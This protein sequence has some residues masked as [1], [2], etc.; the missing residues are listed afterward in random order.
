MAVHLGKV[1]RRAGDRFPKFHAGVG[2]V[3]AGTGDCKVAFIGDSTTVGAGTTGGATKSPPARFAAR[4]TGA[5]TRYGSTWGPLGSGGPWDGRLTVGAGWTTGVSFNSNGLGAGG[6][7]TNTGGGTLSFTPAAAFDT[8]KCWYLRLSAK[9]T[10]TVNVDGG[11]SL[12]SINGAGASALL[13]QTFTCSLGTHTVNVSTPT[14]GDFFLM[15]IETYVASTK[16]IHVY[17]MGFV[18]AGSGSFNQSGQ[19][20]TTVESIATYGFDL[21]IINLSI[22]DIKDNLISESTYASRMS[23]LIGACASTGD[24]ILCMG[25]RT[26]SGPDTDLRYGNFKSSLAAVR[27]INLAI[28]DRW[29]NFTSANGLGFMNVDG[30]HPNDAGSEDMVSAL[31]SLL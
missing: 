19:V 11:A 22:N 14:G 2:R 12:G 31:L 10:V 8:I 9:G 15:G 7:Y 24:V 5:P 30:V 4:Y 27:P 21:S 6:F 1:I 28:P 16:A 29:G 18:G 17:N 23:T 13:S 3:L 25:N 20:Y 26:S